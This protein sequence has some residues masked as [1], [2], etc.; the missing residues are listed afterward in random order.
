MGGAGVRKKADARHLLTHVWTTGGVLAG[1]FIVKLTGWIVLDP[2][3]AVFVAVNIILTGIGLIRRSV[4]G[5][6]DEAL[7][8]E[9][10]STL[11]KIL[12]TLM[13]EGIVNHSLYTRKA[14]SKRFV[15][16]HLV[17]P[18]EW[19]IANGHEVTKTIESEIA[20]VFPE[21]DVFIHTEPM[22]DP[23]A[24]DDYLNSNVEKS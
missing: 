13:K 1:L 11:R 16:L 19:Q 20:R 22:G 10:T 2:I 3:V 21:T 18:G 24:F 15:S 6:M 12:N 9:E 17:M 14:A 23:A 7:P 8:V 5:L 4:S